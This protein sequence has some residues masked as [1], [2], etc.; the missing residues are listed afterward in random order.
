MYFL[1]I[2]LSYHYRNRL[3]STRIWSREELMTPS[4]NLGQCR[5]SIKYKEQYAHNVMT[6]H[7]W[8]VDPR[9]PPPPP[10]PP[11]VAHD[12]GWHNND[13]LSK[14]HDMPD[15]ICGLQSPLARSKPPPPPAPAGRIGCGGTHAPNTLTRPKDRGPD[16]RSQLY[17][18]YSFAFPQPFAPFWCNALDIVGCWVGLI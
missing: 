2:H 13:K 10:L 4:D 12:E 9:P 6:D 18:S 1:D 16:C 7:Q 3:I 17:D 5:K 8:P 11:S 15:H 14:L